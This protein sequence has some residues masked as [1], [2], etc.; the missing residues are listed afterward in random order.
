MVRF[1]LDGNIVSNPI[2]WDTLQSKI[3][4][5]D[6]INAL[7]VTV[8]GRYEFADEGYAYISSIINSDDFCS[9]IEVIIQQNCGNDYVNLFEG[10]ILA[11]DCVLNERT[12]VVNCEVLDRSFF[13]MINNNKRIKTGI[14]S[15]VSKNGD[16]ITIPTAYLVDWTNLSNP[17]IFDRSNV[18]CARI[19][20]VFRYMIAFMTDGRVGFTSTLFGV[21]GEWEGLAITIGER[22]RLTNSA[23]FT[24][25]SFERLY[26]E[27]DNRIPLV[28]LVENPFTAPVVRIEE[29]GYIQGDTVA[30]TLDDIYQIQSSF[31]TS[32]LYSVIKYGCPTFEVAGW[33]I[34][35]NV[36]FFAHKF[37]EFGFLG[38][39]NQDDELD[40]S[41]EWICS[42]SV[43]AQ[44]IS[45]A[46]QTFDEDIYLID[47]D[48]VDATN[49]VTK[50]DN[51]L[52][53]ALGA[54]FFYNS[55]L[56]NYEI[57]LR[58]F[59]NVPNSFA[60]Y[61]LPPG[62]GT[63]KA[64][65]G[66]LATIVGIAVN[67]SFNF[68]NVAFNIG[69]DFNG[70]D[71]FVSPEVGVYNFELFF[72]LN[73]TVGP[74]SVRAQLDIYDDTAVFRGARNILSFGSG[75][76]ALPTGASN[77]TGTVQLILPT[78]WYTVVR[79]LWGGTGTVEVN[80]SSYWSCVSNSIAGGTFQTIDS[81]DFAIRVFDFEYPLAFADWQT[82]LNS[83]RG[84]IYFAMEGQPYRKGWIKELIY[85]HV[86]GTAKFRLLT[87]KATIDVT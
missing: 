83:P 45:N 31:D 34:I 39:C 33:S 69:A 23:T 15:G 35:D 9:E 84:L 60:S 64:F 37:E 53:I 25:F 76:I 40:L 74:K 70:T 8:E 75:A 5:G 68:T 7:L 48:Y 81:A 43:A 3:K 82:I 59:G 63:F 30:I 50:Y 11:S 55:R 51:Y 14:D 32:K 57:S 87:N 2:N 10:T 78:G 56:T 79:V 47:T 27:I 62:T 67:P 29:S 17:L 1:L 26:K 13:A 41:C 42:T 28:L 18:K 85:D 86:K 58:Q 49:G 46:D 16:T 52:N 38:Q 73:V 61:F 71:T 80:T 20:E 77:H 36:T 19:E 66:A 44:I 21:G 72:D 6:D 24:Q 54:R 12:C 22:I 4:R 65:N